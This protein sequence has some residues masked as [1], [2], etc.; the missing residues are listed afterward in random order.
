MF[1]RGL[2][3]FLEVGEGFIFFVGFWSEWVREA[4]EFGLVEVLV[5]GFVVGRFGNMN[6]KKYFVS[7]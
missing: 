6:S 3:V 1:W 5:E 4:V 2:F 7:F